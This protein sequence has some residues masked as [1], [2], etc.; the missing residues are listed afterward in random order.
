MVAQLYTFSE[1]Y[2][3]VSLNQVNFMVCKL[4]FSE[5]VTRKRFGFPIESLHHSCAVAWPPYSQ[6]AQQEDDRELE[7]IRLL[8]Y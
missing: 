7:T 8:L 3:I 5:T 4:Y 1:S 2:R 6:K